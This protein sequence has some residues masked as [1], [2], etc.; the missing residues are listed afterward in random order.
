MLLPRLPLLLLLALGPLLLL[1]LLRWRLLLAARR[2]LLL[3]SRCSRWL[4]RRRGRPARLLRGRR[5]L[6][7]LPHGLQLLPDQPAQLLPCRHRA[8]VRHLRCNSFDGVEK[9]KHLNA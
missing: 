7:R 9:L 4:A 1:L 5:R 2:R 3:P 6:Q 8:L